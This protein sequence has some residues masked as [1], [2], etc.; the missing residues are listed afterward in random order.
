[1]VQAQSLPLRTSH[2]S[3]ECLQ[4]GRLLKFFIPSKCA[5]HLEAKKKNKESSF[6]FNV[7][8]RKE[9]CGCVKKSGSASWIELENEF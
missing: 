3:Q 6:T 2:A 1:M 9:Y 4:N 8:F 5:K 7:T